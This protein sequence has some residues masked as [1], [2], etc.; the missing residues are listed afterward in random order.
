MVQGASQITR[1]CVCS[2]A[3]RFG[4]CL[5]LAALF[6]VAIQPLKAQFATGSY[7]GDG[8]DARA[9]TGL[10]FSPDVVFVEREGDKSTVVRTSTMSGDS[11]KLLALD[12][13]PAANLIE[14]LDADGFTV[15]TNDAVNKSPETYHW[16]AFKDAATRVDVGSY[17]GDG[18]DNRSITGVGFQPDY[19]AVMSG[20]DKKGVHRFSSQTGDSSFEFN[21]SD[22]KSDFIQAM[23]TDG[24]QVG[25]SNK[26]NDN[27][28]T[29]HY[30]AF[31]SFAGKVNVGSYA[32]DGNDNRNITGVGFQPEWVILKS[33]AKKDGLH[34][35]SSIP[36]ATDLALRFKDTGSQTNAIQAL[37][38]DGFQVG[39]DDRS[40]KSGDTFYW[41]AFEEFGTGYA[42]T[43]SGGSTS[44]AE[45]GTTDTFTVVLDTEPDSNV[46][47]TV[48][49]GDT[50]EATVNVSSL[51]FTSGNWST[52]QTVTVTGVD[53][54]LIDGTQNTTVTLSIDDANSD[55]SFDPLADQT[56]SASTTD[57]D[58][59]GFTIVESG[60]S[61]S[62]AESGTTDT[63]TVVLDAEPDSNVVIL[64][65]SGDTGEATVNVSSLTFIPAAWNTAQTVTVTGVD[66]NLIDGNQNTTI[67]LSIDDANSDD[68]FDPLANQTVSATT[69]DDDV[70][71]FTIVESGGS[72]SVAESGT[73][74]TFTVVLDAEPDSN[75]VILVSSG[76]TGEAT[77]NVAS[78]TFIPASWNT[79]QTVTVTGVDDN[80]IDGN[81]NTT[82]TLSIDDANSDD[83]FDPL[84]NQTVS[85]TTTDDDVAGFT[86]VESG[87]STSVAESGTTDTF[88]VVLDAEPDSNVVILVSSGDTGEATVNVSSL[89]FIPAAWNTAQTV[90]VTGVDDNLIDGNQN[91]TITLSIDDANSDDNFDPLANQTVSAT[92]T[93][94][95]VAG[96]TIVESGGSTSV[97]ES[98]T[99]DTFTVVLDAEPDSNVVILVSSGDTGEATVNV[100]S[101]TFIPASWNTA[102]TVTV[103]GV[104]DNLIDGNQNT[105]ITLSI[106]DANSDDNFDPLA[107]QTVSATTTD[108]DVAGFTIV[109]SGGS[110]S[111]AES[112][113]TDTF[114]V[115]LDAEPDSNVVILVSSGDTGEATVNVASLTFIPAAWNTAQTVTVTGVD[116]NLIDGNQNTTITLSIDDANS[117]D[118]FD[119]LANQTV[120]ATTTDDDV[121]GFTI[122]ESGGST[123]VA[124]SGTTDT[125]T[126]VLDAE[127]D[128]NVVILVSS[129]DTGEATVN[130]ASLTFIP[131]SWNTAQTVTVT[132]VDD[133]LI[134]GNQNTTITLSIDDANSDDNFDPL[135]NQT[136]SATTTDDDVAG[137]TIVESGGSTSVA[138]SGTTDTFTVVLD[139]EPDSNVV[140]LVSSGDTGEATVN[141]ASLTFIP[142]SWNTAQT[143]TVTGVDDNLIDGNQNTTITLSI[144]DANSDDNFDPLANQMV[145]A[146]TTDD[147]VAGFTIVESGGST[148][149]A[150]SGTTDTFTVVLDAEP[151]SNVVILVSSGDTGEATVNVASLTF[152]PASWNTAQTV[153]VTGVDDNL[154]DGNQNTTITLSIDDANSDDNFDPLANQTV[155]AT[156]TDDDVA[157]FTIVESSGSTSVA[158]SGTTDTFTVVLDAEPDSN[159][160]ILVSSGDTGEATV[161]VA[162]L[163]F[164]PAA[165]NT[166]QTVTVTGV[167]DNLIDGNQ[168]TTITL[169]IDDANSDDNFDPLANQTVSA[170]TTDDDVAGFTI[171]ESSGSTSVAES[172]TTDTFTVVLDAE[173]DS[174]VVIL[175][176]SGDTGEATVNVSS[177][178]F[179]PASWNTA[180]TVTVTGVDDNLIDG[181]Q[182]TTITLSI[183]DANSDDNFDPLANQTVSA[184]TTDDD[185]AGFT[186]VE[187]GGSTSVAESGTTDTFTVV[188]DAEPDSNVVILVSSGDT[189]EATANVSS[190]TFIPAAWNTA[191]TVTVTGVDDNLIDGNQNTTIT[192]SIDDTNSDDNFDPLA[193]QTVSATTTDDD[194]AGFTIVESGGATSVAE[195]GTTDTF[196][197][198]LDA[199][200]DSNVVIL[201]SSG[202]TG[203]ATVNVA[204]LTFIPA[205]WN[206]AQTVTVTGV[207]DNLIDGNQ[208]TTIT[209]SIDDANS[210]DNFDPLANQTVSATTTDDDVAGF[211]IVESGGSTSVAESGTTDTFTVVLDAEPDSNVVI[212]VSSGDTG[213]A[214]VNVSSLT[215]IPAAWNTAQ[216]VTVTGVDDNLIDGNQNT[217]ITLSIDDANSDD[218]FD[219]LANQTVSATTTDDDVA[220]FTIVESGGSTSVAESGT[221][222]TFTVVLDAEPDS[223]VVILVSSGDTGEATVNVASLTFIPAAWNT[224]QTVTVTGVDDNLIDGNQNTTI[225]LSIDD[226]NSDDN[227]DPLANQTVSATTTDDDVAGFTIVESGGSTSVAESGT[228]DTFT[229]VLDAEP[230]SNVVILVSSGDTGEHGQRLLADVHPGGLEHR[231]D[232]HGHGS[233]RQP[234]R[235]QPEH[236]NHAEHR[237]RQLGR[238]L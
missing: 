162:S 110:T 123:S 105:R 203:E 6:L 151:D 219:P 121:A 17:A 211:T 193:N 188:L 178:T 225:T 199:E 186:I 235:W 43:E 134:D 233:R 48:T 191:Q 165:W 122:V 94:D 58:V 147:D 208:N 229:V 27:G 155:S 84:A 81:Q 21:A 14:S 115:V 65:S 196:T 164:I 149:V 16:I 49:S 128:S 20:G 214:T 57:D 87:G 166:A 99:T 54:N 52:A 85:A 37:Q 173:P 232:G 150:E 33:S 231:P 12:S 207:D 174:N 2:P 197:V 220:G 98:G 238:Q 113:T 142:V 159:V 50:G 125:F 185:V 107:N 76:D 55:D 177:L 117:D 237:R 156:T 9:I 192:L 46:V 35:P 72:T 182:N 40:N 79:A 167:D 172:G 152:I 195:S 198:V 106:D 78:L 80:L 154:I 130:V 222:D 3:G 25:G 86:I 213:E 36:S 56:V 62:V 163:T 15:G 73:T 131:V 111:V 44:V 23:E 18:A 119:P 200:P 11:A 34:R 168:N 4:Q 60:G 90:T 181:N 129:G 91:T 230:D 116:D 92:T 71:G 77:V 96:F 215:F 144:D 141:V 184:T 216:T 218:N 227:F 59:A 136:V 187:S 7:T 179:I 148:S 157:G 124:E 88:T 45:S 176:S 68:N 103:T 28:T 101:L 143:V 209:L 127:P 234:D 145:S 204:S 66:D 114:T 64:V 132:G 135:A 61:T 95:D 82:I 138:E 226:A 223:N 133:N 118:N 75:V 126:V 13:N 41:A 108:D 228:T 224:A 70:A 146:T 22:E 109:E 53:D 189:G 205:S 39:S 194:V 38:S 26:V 139:A 74:D 19:V 30:I 210:D 153:T 221:T 140:I 67:T 212:L 10:G 236:H 104:D 1:R 180:Q 169:S 202:D 89:T 31:K 160:V 217:T 206:T 100:A 24:F 5:F 137:F 171:V 183:D 158:E 69:T 63:F 112:G 51:T 83:N 93:D 8:N 42:V 102:Q 32:G 175:V 29:F 161:N 170:T 201:V 47:I 190:L 97:A 120:S